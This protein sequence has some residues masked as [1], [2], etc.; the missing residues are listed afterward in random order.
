MKLEERYPDL[1]LQSVRHYQYRLGNICGRE[2]KTTLSPMPVPERAR[3]AHEIWQIDAKERFCIKNGQQ[4][5]Y[6]T[7]IDEASGILL[8]AQAFAYARISQVPIAEIKLFL[9]NMFKFWTMPLA[10]KT[11]NGKPFGV[12]QR[13][14][15]PI[16][17][18][19]L[20]AWGINPI[21]T[22]P[23]HPTDNPKVERAQGTTSRWAELGACEDVQMLQLRLNEA[24]LFQ[25]E[26]YKVRRLGYVTRCQLFKDISNKTRPFE[27]A[28]FHEKR[29]YIYLAS[30]PLP[31]MVSPKGT[32][33]IY[34]QVYSIGVQYKKQ[35]VTLKYSPDDT[36]WL[37]LEQ[38]GKICKTIPDTKFTRDNLFNLTCQ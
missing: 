34:G 13:D 25:R 33:S 36:A 29:A 20:K 15:I 26:V 1:K 10:I 18:L 14:R 28:I 37:V 27:Q 31:R 16:M 3:T 23:R 6:L 35:V 24:C 5:C 7:I 8:G 11:D 12:P 30:I 21:L 4:M 2:P 38:S 19:W 22:R 17:S 32:V 9:I